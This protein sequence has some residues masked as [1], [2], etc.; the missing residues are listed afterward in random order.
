MSEPSHEITQLVVR[1]SRGDDGAFED[2][3]EAVYDELRQ[4]ARHHL[5]LGRRDEVLNTTVLVHEAYL[6]LARVDAWDGRGRAQ[7]FAFCSRAMRHVLVDF[8]RRRGAA[9]RGGERIRVELHDDVAAIDAA[10]LDLLVVE[11]ALRR[12]ESKSERM[13]RVFECRHF[14]GMTVS[15][16]AEALDT[17]ERTV[18]REWARARAYLRVALESGPADRGVAVRG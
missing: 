1:W 17:S 4:I 15:E 10:A 7:F 11:D 6:R 3:V 2:L 12:L 18:A 16:T 8:A 5:E 9:K 14:G 13:A